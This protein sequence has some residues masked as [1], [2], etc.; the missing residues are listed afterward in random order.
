MSS[1]PLLFRILNPIMK[2]LLKSP[3]HSAVSDRIMI[4]TFT[5]KK[6]G[7]LYSTPVTYY[8]EDGTVVCFTHGRWWKNLQGG[9]DVKLRVRGQDVAGRAEAVPDDE[10]LKTE[11]LGKMIKAAPGDAR[12]YD[13]S[14]DESGEPNAGD[15]QRAAADAV[16]IRI[17][18]GQA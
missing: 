10:E 7:K 1:T 17:A 13:V 9:A 8:Q 18:L 2:G 15:I 4:I 6:S 3:F 16:M 11:C 5:G 14:F 12:F